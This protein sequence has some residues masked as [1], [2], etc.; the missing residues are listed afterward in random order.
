MLSLPFCNEN[1]ATQSMDRGVELDVKNFYPVI[2]YEKCLSAERVSTSAHTGF[3]RE[4]T[5]GWW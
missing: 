4:R 1:H 2:H 3:A 5:K